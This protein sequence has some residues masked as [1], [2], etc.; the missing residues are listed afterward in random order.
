MSFKT[1]PVVAK[2]LSKR[3][4]AAINKLIHGGKD[5]ETNLRDRKMLLSANTETLL[6]KTPLTEKVGSKRDQHRTM[7][8]VRQTIIFH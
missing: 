1:E 7:E 2:L 8:Q 3:L 6:K 4:V 5:E